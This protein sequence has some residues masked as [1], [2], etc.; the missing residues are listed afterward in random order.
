V[1]DDVELNVEYARNFYDSDQRPLRSVLRNFRGPMLIIHGTRDPLVPI[2]A[3]NEHHLLVPQSELRILDDN[4]FMAF[5]RPFI[6][7]QPL[8]EFLERIKQS[9]HAV[10]GGPYRKLSTNIRSVS[11]WIART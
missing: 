2:A 3:A 4:H 9:A 7:I 5:Q 11:A 8:Q 10:N 6:L 1:L